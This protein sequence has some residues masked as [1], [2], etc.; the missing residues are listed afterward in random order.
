MEVVWGMDNV[1][2]IVFSSVAFRIRVEQREDDFK[3]EEVRSSA[4]RGGEEWRA[5][6]EATSKRLLGMNRKESHPPPPTPPSSH[7]LNSFEQA[8]QHPPPNYSLASSRPCNT[9][10]SRRPSGSRDPYGGTN[11]RIDR[12]L[13][14]GRLL[15]G[16]GRGEER[17][18]GT[19]GRL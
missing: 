7:L 5:R 15:G 18:E 4:K 14:F 2:L 19:S 12:A 16:E 8:S 3:G 10:S 6:R 11:G 9:Y 1:R 17:R 13:K